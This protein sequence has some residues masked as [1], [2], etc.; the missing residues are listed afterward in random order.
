MSL[1]RIIMMVIILI[2]LIVLLRYIFSDPY[3]LQHLQNAK[4]ASTI[5]ATSL[6]NGGSNVPLSNFAYSVW[7]YINDW[8]YR[9]GEP[10]VIYGRMD[11]TSSS[12]SG[13]VSGISGKGPCPVVHLGETENNLVVSL[14]CFPSGSSESD[15]IVP[16]IHRCQ[17][18]NV[19]I[20]RWVNL[21]LSVYGRTLDVYLDGKLVKTC[22]L[23][24]VAKINNSSNIYVTPNG[25]FDGFTSKLQY[26]PSPLNPQDA[27]NIY[28]RGYGGNTISNMFG[29]GTSS[30]SSR[31]QI[32]LSLVKN[33][34]TEKTFSF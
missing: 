4:T 7:F 12:S 5:P 21:S 31:S 16:V 1:S 17:V 8:N 6:A 10:K 26:F 27:W 23:P 18:S 28:S 33:G 29:L 11:S 2:L 20:Q 14:A 34:V 3:T 13:D 32:E 25:G 24:G 22:L 15:K 19:P 9:Y 30:S